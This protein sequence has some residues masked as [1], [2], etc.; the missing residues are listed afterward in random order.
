M[1]IPTL[2]IPGPPARAAAISATLT[3]IAALPGADV[4]LHNLVAAFARLSGRRDADDAP[5]AARRQTCRD[6]SHAIEVETVQDETWD[7]TSYVGVPITPALPWFQAQIDA[8]T[9]SDDPRQHAMADTAARELAELLPLVKVEGYTTRRESGK[10]CRPAEA[11]A[12]PA[13]VKALKGSRTWAALAAALG[14]PSSESYLRAL[15]SGRSFVLREK[16]EGW[17]KLLNPAP[18]SPPEQETP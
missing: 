10:W 18:S 11:Y 3:Q 4:P 16:Y 1:T 8:W 7:G 5:T 9:D 2:T 15:A 6:L 17:V 13:E 14:I 12:T